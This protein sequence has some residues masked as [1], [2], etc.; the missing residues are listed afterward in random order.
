[1]KSIQKS[2]REHLAQQHPAGTQPE[3]QPLNV[4]E[5]VYEVLAEQGQSLDEEARVLMEPRFGHDFSQVRIHTD[6][7]AAE[8]ARA[9]QAQAYAVGR[10]VVFDTGKYAPRTTSGQWLLAHEL[11]HVVQQEG[12]TTESGEL[13]IGEPASSLEQ[14]ASA[15]A[16][17]VVAGRPKAIPAQRD[18]EQRSVRRYQ[19]GDEGHGGIEQNALTKA[20]FTAKEARSVY[21]GNWLRDLS[22]LPPKALPLIN[23]LALGEFG[24][25]IKQEDLGTYVPSEHLDNP[26][27]GGTYEDPKATPD[28]KKEAWDR[29]SS[30]Q[31]TAY[32]DEQ[33]HIGEITSAAKASGLPVYIERGKYHAKEKLAQAVDAGRTPE[34]MQEMGN[35]LHA[36]E[37]YFSHSNFVEVA[38]WNLHNEGSIT[39][40]QYNELV[41]SELGHDV[42]TLG[43]KDPLDPTQPGII[44]GTYAPGANSNVSLLELI[45]TEAENGELAK[46]FIKGYMLK[47][48]ITI[49]EVL[50]KAV[51]GGYNLGMKTGSAFGGVTGGLL[52][53]AIG[54]VGG[55]V[56][57]AISGAAEGWQTHSGLSALGH[58][59]TG[60]FGGAASGAVSGAEKGYDVGSDLGQR[61]GAA[62]GGGI[63]ATAGALAGLTL[64]AIINTLGTS[65]LLLLFPVIIAARIAMI[66]SA[67]SGILEMLSQQQT[68]KAA[69]D[70]KKQGLGPTHSEIAKDSP[71]HKLFGV[72][73]ALAKLADEEI[74]KAMLSAWDEQAKANAVATASPASPA[75]TDP[76]TSLVD[77]YVSHPS[78]DNWWHS[79]LLGL[80]KK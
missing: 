43:G 69:L 9:V 26:E 19:A 79:T 15:T 40:T 34:G 2:V 16:D 62:V 76:V 53:G 7:R 78:R 24:R 68:A 46:S 60:F 14:E 51:S 29:M 66:A 72:S 65:L 41:Q 5:S 80:I 8:S 49:K 55:T 59:I 48:G 77:K 75:I 42:A 38:I 44:T 33:K 27:G 36:V 18:G 74:G 56:G 70:A 3:R 1:M 6:E 50:E 25:E 30:D 10:D 21:F 45:C 35:A 58:A 20:G 71:R 47:Q 11:T 37:D 13:S 39:A 64:D 31:R 61:A 67:R 4:P 12:L 63:G 32:E 52:G 73:T 28:Q 22:Q 17:Q 57:G 23:I 54:G